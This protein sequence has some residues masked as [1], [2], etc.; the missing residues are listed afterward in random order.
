MS[1]FFLCTSSR[2]SVSFWKLKRS[3]AIIYY[4]RL[5][6]RLTI[7]SLCHK[8]CSTWRFFLFYAKCIVCVV[9]DLSNCFTSVHYS[10]SL[11]RFTLW[12]SLAPTAPQL[13]TPTYGFS[14]STQVYVFKPAYIIWSHFQLIS[15]RTGYL[16]SSNFKN[17]FKCNSC[18]RAQANDPKTFQETVS[19]CL[20]FTQALMHS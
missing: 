1:A 20:T 16:L 10:C 15:F 9:W 6:H 3:K 4:H 14:T 17:A 8:R 7:I 12:F 18:K 11:C 13:W 5:T 2:Y 19:C